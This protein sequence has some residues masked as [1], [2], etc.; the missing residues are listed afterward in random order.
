VREKGTSWRRSLTPELIESRRI[1]RAIVFAKK[2][3]KKK[4]RRSQERV[5]CE[6][7]CK[8][9]RIT[10]GIQQVYQRVNEAET[11]SSDVFEDNSMSGLQHRWCAV[12]HRGRWREYYRIGFNIDQYARSR[13]M[14]IPKNPSA[15]ISQIVEDFWAEK[16]VC[17][18]YAIDLRHET[19]INPSS[20]SEYHPSISL[21]VA[22]ASGF[23]S[24][25]KLASE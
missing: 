13:L 19:K 10:I 3:K 1:E 18:Q 25:R 24:W 20:V 15:A 23:S 6:P 8:D 16:K 21:A 14:Y 9:R 4:V 2:K 5:T 17:K 22:C 12:A 7:A 11:S